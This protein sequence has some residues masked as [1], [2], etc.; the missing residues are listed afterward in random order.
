MWVVPV[1]QRWLSWSKQE[2][3]GEGKDDTQ[4]ETEMRSGFHARSIQ[5]DW[6]MTLAKWPLGVS[7]Q[8]DENSNDVKATS[9]DLCESKFWENIH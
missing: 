8:L 2:G 4:Q 1:N 5:E 6:R 3:L 9:M 7:L